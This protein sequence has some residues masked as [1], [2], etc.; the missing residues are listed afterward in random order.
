MEK[1]YLFEFP[2]GTITK[3]RELKWSTLEILKD[4]CAPR[5]IVRIEST[6]TAK[7]YTVTPAGMFSGSSPFLDEK[8][9][10]P[11]V[12]KYR[13]ILAENKEEMFEFALCGSHVEFF[14]E[15][16]AST[17]ARQALGSDCKYITTNINAT[18]KYSIS[19]TRSKMVVALDYSALYDQMLRVKGLSPALNVEGNS[20]GS[21]ST[22]LLAM[23]Q[24]LPFEMI[25]KMAM[26]YEVPT[27]L[28]TG[29]L[30]SGSIAHLAAIILRQV[31]SSLPENAP[32]LTVKAVS[33]SG[34]LCVSLDL[35]SYLERNG[36]RENHT[37]IN[38][39]KDISDRL[40]A[41]FQALSPLESCGVDSWRF[42][43]STIHSYTKGYLSADE[44]SL[45][46]AS[47]EVN[48][49][50]LNQVEM[51][52]KHHAAITTENDL[53]PVGRYFLKNSNG[54]V[55]MISDR[56]EVASVVW[57]FENKKFNFKK[58]SYS[59]LDLNVASFEEEL[60]AKGRRADLYDI[61]PKITS[62]RIMITGERVALHFMGENLDTVV[63]RLNEES[64]A[65]LSI[66]MQNVQLLP[67]RLK[68]GKMK[69]TNQSK[70]LT[71][72]PSWSKAVVEL[73][74]V[75][76][77]STGE[78]T[79]KTDFGESNGF[80]YTAEHVI[81]CEETPPSK[82][83][84]PTMNAEFL[85]AA[86]LRV[87]ICCKPYIQKEDFPVSVK[88]IG[89]YLEDNPRIFEVLKLLLDLEGRLVSS[90]SQRN[91]QSNLIQ[92]LNNEIDIS[93]MRNMSLG[94]F[95]ILSR[96]TT[97]D[98]HVKES[99]F[100]KIGRKVAASVGFVTG[101]LLGIA[102][103]IMMI[104]AA[105]VVAPVSG[106]VER[107]DLSRRARFGL[108]A[109]M[110]LTGILA[111]PGTIVGSIGV[112]LIISAQYA[113]RDYQT[114]KYKQ[115]LKSLLTILGGNIQ[116]IVDEVPSLEDSLVTM[117]SMN[118]PECNLS[119]CSAKDITTCM[120]RAISKESEPAIKIK[121]ELDHVIV[122]PQLAIEKLLLVGRINA[123]RNILE[124]NFMIGFI[125]VHNSGKSTTI[126]KLF[127]CETNPNL[128]HRTEEP[129]CHLLGGWI[130]RLA[131]TNQKFHDWS[132]ES[133]H[134]KLQLYAVD[135][136]GT[137]DERVSVSSMTRYTAEL[138]SFFIIIL[139][140]GHIAGPEKE[141]VK[142]AKD[143]H[144]P[145]L[146]I[147]NQCDVIAHELKNLST[148]EKLRENYAKALDVAEGDLIFA[149]AFKS[150]DIDRLRGYIFGMIQNLI[151]NPKLFKT[152]PLHFLTDAIVAQLQAAP[153]P[154]DHIFEDFPDRLSEAISSLLFGFLPLQRE[155]IVEAIKK[156]NENRQAKLMKTLHPTK[157]GDLLPSLENIIHKDEV[158]V[159]SGIIGSV[160]DYLRQIACQLNVDDDVYATCVD[161]IDFRLEEFSGTVSFTV[162]PAE[163]HD[164]N[165]TRQVMDAVLG[166]FALNY[167]ND[168]INQYFGNNRPNAA[169]IQDS[170]ERLCP[171]VLLGL[172]V[173]FNTWISRGYK[174]Y[175][176][177]IALKT[178]LL[179]DDVF[180]DS[181]ALQAIQEVS[182]TLLS[183]EKEEEIAHEKYLKLLEEQTQKTAADNDLKIEVV[184]QRSSLS[185]EDLH[186]S[187]KSNIS[188]GIK[189]ALSVRTS[190][191]NVDPL[192]EVEK[193]QNAKIQFNLLRSLT[194]A[195]YDR[196]VNVH[197][198]QTSNLEDFRKGL[199]QY[200]R[201]LFEPLFIPVKSTQLVEDVL[202]GLLSL[203]DRQLTTKEIKFIIQGEPG[204]DVNGVTRSVLSKC[205]E[206]IN[207]KPE[208]V[209]LKRDSESGF[210][211][212]DPKFCYSPDPSVKRETKM[213]YRGL[214]R[215]IGLTL[216]KSNNGAT[217]PLNFPITIYK[218][219]LHYRISFLDLSIISP[220]VTNSVQQMCLMNEEELTEIGMTF[221]LNLD[222]KTTIDLV[223]NGQEIAVN[224][225]NRI[226]YLTDVLQVNLCCF[227]VESPVTGTVAGN[228]GAVGSGVVGGV[229]GGGGGVMSPTGTGRG[230][231][232]LFPSEALLGV[233]HLCPRDL[234]NHLSPTNL[235]LLV[236]GHRDINIEDWKN[237]TVIS[238]KSYENVE[239]ISLFWEVVTKHMTMEDHRRLLCFT[240]GTSTL[241]S[242]GFQALEPKFQLVIGALPLD[243]LPT[244]HACFHMLY[245]PRYTNLETM[246]EKLL[247]AILET[248]ETHL[249]L[250]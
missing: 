68:A 172:H 83:L 216:R 217:L 167:L 195:T 82:F 109:I 116:D 80:T 170:V 135:F 142:I 115:M 143:N 119:S 120:D 223:P 154:Y 17:K 75:E 92:Y 138:A 81:R 7:V 139:K 96:K 226:D 162:N 124:N 198:I 144:K 27:I 22:E 112:F 40:I 69:I 29:S 55:Q 19:I 181:H 238:N 177:R 250:V 73:T 127:G 114:T 230:A 204:V 211:Y 48:I 11:P 53:K 242:G 203:E 164:E 145:Y 122:G 60:H 239:T 133:N 36:Q 106:L 157:K 163:V 78:I 155:T 50:T 243:A 37:T 151:G 43:Y 84:H 63:M 224:V 240:I 210:L 86:M 62:F 6:T 47:N 219:L 159:R 194:F 141:V 64:E 140:A 126:N 97:E 32:H 218:W 10:P 207:E 245:L 225:H 18:T 52:L 168:R 24:V 20:F 235:Q 220:Q 89:G 130:D 244:S 205:S 179:S 184:K 123:I 190:S 187:E 171:Q 1:F 56:P 234:F 66:T 13:V 51:N 249:G 185:L 160:F 189:R 212:F 202:S 178:L 95:E 39:N 222:E 206:I 16:D 94:T 74:N 229:P 111:L 49:T 88:K 42:I 213:L 61:Q 169:T 121:K 67:F 33:F 228:G 12:G 232:D 113:A 23:A 45:Q 158:E 3:A 236:E 200:T 28:F 156:L 46:A 14:K 99:P 101:G 180:D 131:K 8:N 76:F 57:A 215:L 25:M 21:V 118:F 104:P 136:P 30:W 188:P 132:I 227:H 248:D 233:Q 100:R 98:F 197:S 108:R 38:S 174:P 77:D 199:E 209:R 125:G 137:T 59:L 26:A 237:N 161:A 192:A 4:Q 129:A 201:N 241:P 186:L 128:I 87:A 148:F 146:I 102:A 208:V 176:V 196:I 2:D 91:L 34:P 173:I 247:Y 5:D 221:E 35:S 90:P 58:P 193:F 65:L 134:S 15:V 153:E 166:L 110:G 9:S 72:I 183:L 246:K 117:F 231:S 44:S 149:S 147:I 79:L 165:G 93:T 182:N 54:E 71:V 31:C 152:L 103:M 41:D 85:S 105:I 70:L 150:T 214:G 191:L 107:T 175:V